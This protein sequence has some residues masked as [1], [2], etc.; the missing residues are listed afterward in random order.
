MINEVIAALLHPKQL[1]GIFY[2]GTMISMPTLRPILE[3]VVLSS[4]MKLDGNSMNKLFDLMTMM[5]KYQLETVTGPRELILSTLNHI[6]A[7][8]EMATDQQCIDYVDSTYKMIMDVS[9]VR[10][11][12]GG[13]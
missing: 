13:V 9:F 10:L 5:V 6:D 3:T 8:R 2:P 4:I 7:L 11:G 1:E 12:K